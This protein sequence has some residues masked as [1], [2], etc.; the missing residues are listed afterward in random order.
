[1]NKLNVWTR[2]SLGVESIANDPILIIQGH[3]RSFNRESFRDA[4]T[5]NLF[6][7]TSLGEL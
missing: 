6:I 7:H 2:Q 4:Q 3:L 1:M 5:F